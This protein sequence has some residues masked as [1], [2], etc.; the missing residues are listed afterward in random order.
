MLSILYTNYRLQIELKLGYVKY[1]T[2]YFIVLESEMN[3]SFIF[4]IQLSHKLIFIQPREEKS[5]ID[6]ISCCRS[7]QRW[8][9]CAVKIQLRRK[10]VKKKHS[11][12]S[13]H[14]TLLNYI[15]TILQSY[16]IIK[17]EYNRHNY[18]GSIDG[19]RRRFFHH[20]NQ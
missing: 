16:R 14:N 3:L 7:W 10:P 20:S 8:S 11:W 19:N 15:E 4:S 1:N 6:S 2:S 5:E 9:L 18:H 13:K 12:I 17:Y